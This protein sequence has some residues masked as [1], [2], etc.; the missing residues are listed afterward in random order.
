METSLQ[1]VNLADRPIEQI[2]PNMDMD[3]SQQGPKRQGDPHLAL[4]LTFRGE[5]R[6]GFFSELLQPSSVDVGL[7]QLTLSG[8]LSWTVVELENMSFEDTLVVSGTE[9]AE[10]HASFSCSLFSEM[11]DRIR[12]HCENSAGLSMNM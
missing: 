2:K 1:P 11:V 3:E 4:D 8:Q 6:S 7:L 9:C 12:R 10:R 5:G